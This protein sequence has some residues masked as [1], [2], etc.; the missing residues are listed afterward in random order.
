MPGSSSK[1]CLQNLVIIDKA[2]KI[3]LEI[4][5]ELD[6][7]LKLFVIFNLSDVSQGICI[8]YRKLEY[9]SFRKY[10][11]SVHLQLFEL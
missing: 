1:F 4:S 8:I 3:L 6:F 9:V 5:E 2:Y 10:I 7:E 11:Y